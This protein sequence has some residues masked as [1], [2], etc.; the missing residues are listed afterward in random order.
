[1]KCKID[2]CEN[3]ASYKT[4]AVCQKHYFRMM[5]NG[6]Y[7]I[8]PKPRAERVEN[9]KGYQLIDSPK[10]PLSQSNGYVY[11]HRMK[12]Y[13]KYGENIPDC[14]FCG[15]ETS[16]APYKT[17]I[18]H[19]DE[20]V[21][22]NEISNLRVLCNPCNTGRTKRDTANWERTTTLEFEGEVKTPFAWASDERVSISSATIRRRKLRGMTDEEALFSPSKTRSDEFYKAKCKELLKDLA[23]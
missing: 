17:H 7:E 1:M 22:N 13:E 18:D 19:I 14:E 8:T 21:R 6:T 11:E 9:P 15:K 10:H 5:R 4:Q 23:A 12:V 3:T 16:W 2:G 20:N